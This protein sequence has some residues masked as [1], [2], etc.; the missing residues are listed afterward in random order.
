ME[1]PDVDEM[2]KR[3]KYLEK[4]R[5]ADFLDAAFYMMYYNRQIKP[6]KEPLDIEP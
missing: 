3:S 4:A 5:K 2:E 6:L 1:V